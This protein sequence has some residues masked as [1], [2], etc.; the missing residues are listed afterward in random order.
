MRIQGAVALSFG[1]C[2]AWFPGSANAALVI[3]GAPTNNVNC[4]GGVCTA[5]AA[6]AVLNVKDLRAILQHGPLAIVSGPEAQDIEIDRDFHWTQRHHLTLDAFRSIVFKQAVISEARSAVTLITNDGGTDGDYSFTGKGHLSFW[7]T[8]SE[9][10]INGQTFTLVTDIKT[11]AS[12]I[13]ANSSGAYALMRGY[14]ASV[15]QTY[16]APPIKYDFSGTFE[17][18]GHV[19]SNLTIDISYPYEG[20]YAGLFKRIVT[21]SVVRDI[22]LTSENIFHPPGRSITGGLVAYSLGT[23]VNASVEANIAAGAKGMTGGLVGANQG[24]I[25]RSS[26]IGSTSS[27]SVGGRYPAWTGGLVGGNSGRISGSFAEGIVTAGRFSYVG[28][29]VGSGVG[30]VSD[31]YSSASVAGAKDGS[32][33]G[34]LIGDSDFDIGSSYSTGSISVQG[35]TKSVLLGG[36]LGDDDAYPVGA[37]AALIGILTRPV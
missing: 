11:L 8:K 16:H 21:G 5:T 1:L 34:G 25:L 33:I 13:A 20:K 7:D 9:L 28:G 22:A 31:C 19:I 2:F 3:S 23:I 6:D 36:L 15:D 30:V 26:A 17:G 10:V 37:L 35:G 32:R 24:A 27:E 18:L 4:A 12:D 14:D 29:L